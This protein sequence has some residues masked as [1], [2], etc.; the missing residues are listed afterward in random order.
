MSSREGNVFW[1]VFLR[2]SQ[3]NKKI[4]NPQ[5]RKA[6]TEAFALCCPNTFLRTNVE[7]RQE[8]NIVGVRGGEMSDSQK[9][10][11]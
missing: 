2:L 11:V 6:A 4:K 10:C 5:L 9:Q 8:N 1:G 3:F 7:F